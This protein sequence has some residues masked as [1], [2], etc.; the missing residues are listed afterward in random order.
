MLDSVSLDQ[1]RSFIAAADQ[2]SFSVAARKLRRAQSAVS[3]LVSG[4]EA[5]LGSRCSTVRVA[6]R[7]G[8]REDETTM[9]IGL[10]R[11]MRTLVTQMA[12]SRPVR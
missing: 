2:G 11:R 6:T 8:L 5:K 3:E 7:R 9:E 12:R 1:L 4:L 10:P